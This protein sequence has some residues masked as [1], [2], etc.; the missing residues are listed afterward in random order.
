MCQF[1]IMFHFLLFYPNQH[2]VCASLAN[3]MWIQLA[4]QV[5]LSAK[6]HCS[7]CQQVVV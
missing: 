2:A 4:K 7:S 6:T 3:L 1:A 5:D